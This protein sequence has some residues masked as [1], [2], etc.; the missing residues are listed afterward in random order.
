M[1]QQAW[2]ERHASPPGACITRSTVLWLKSKVVTLIAFDLKGAF[3]G[4][5]KISLDTRLYLQGI[6][7]VVRKWIRSFMEVRSASIKFDDFETAMEPL[8][9][10]GLAQG[11]PLSPMLFTLFNSDLVD[12]RVD[13]HC[14]ASASIDDYF[15]WRIVGSAADNMKRIQDEDM[16]RIEAWARRTG[17]C[18]A[19]EKPS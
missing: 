11:S 18:F 19:V 10:A 16:P 12:Q 6:P 3:D 13:L 5:K 9:N 4:V 8:E 2:A 14:G 7:S 1:M 15:R 17:S